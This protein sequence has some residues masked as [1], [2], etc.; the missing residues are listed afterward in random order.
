[1]TP[2]S[3]LKRFLLKNRL[4]VKTGSREACTHTFLDGGKIALPE[5]ATPDFFAAYG[6]DLRAR[7]PLFVVERRTEVFQLHFDV[8]FPSL[9]DDDR[10]LEFCR[11]VHATVGEYFAAPKRCVVCAVTEEGRSRRKAPG[12]HIIFPRTPVVQEQALCIR[13]GVVARCRQHLRWLEDWDKAIDVCVLKEGGSLRLVGSDKCVP[14]PHCRNGARERLSCSLCVEGHLPQDKVYWP[15][16]VL[17]EDER[18]ATELQDFHANEA[19]AARFCSIRTLLSEPDKSYL[20]PPGAPLASCRRMKL[21]ELGRMQ[22]C[23]EYYDHEAPFKRLGGAPLAVEQL[24]EAVLRG[25]TACVQGYCGEHAALTLKQVVR[26]QGAQK[27]LLKVTGFGSRF[28]TNKGDHHSK[29]NI[30]FH[31]S[32]FGLS[33]RCFSKSSM[34]RAVGGC[35]CE[36]FKGLTRELPVDLLEHLF[37]DAPPPTRQRRLGAM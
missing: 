1:M 14:C 2:P 3:T 33:Q 21:T 34:V 4:Y 13:S 6:E 10:V 26:I 7:R 8:D 17:P 31:L 15:W 35:P 18:A 28:C 24:S 20:P 16:R 9:L 36:S 32:R 11:L 27:Y 25:L 19:H 22:R 12:L 5:A 23:L 30:Y 37:Q 29:S